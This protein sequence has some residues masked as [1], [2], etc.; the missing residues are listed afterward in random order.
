MLS[1]CIWSLKSTISIITG[2][3]CSY[4]IY[5]TQAPP[6]KGATVSPWAA[7]VDWK[8]NSCKK[9]L[10][11]VLYFSIF[12]GLRGTA[13]LSLVLSLYSQSLYEPALDHNMY[14]PALDSHRYDS[15]RRSH[16]PR[17]IF[18]YSL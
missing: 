6:V 1:E 5:L 9:C 2:K 18:S 12:V 15:S 17:H 13:L 11:S 7:A 10:G 8:G 14:E 16:T 4:E 3:S